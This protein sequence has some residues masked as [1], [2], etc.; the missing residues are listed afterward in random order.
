MKAQLKL[1]V[2]P[3]EEGLHKRL[4][5]P[6]YASEY[7]KT[8]LEDNEAPEVFLIAL[9]DVAEA[10]GMT[11][12]AQKVKV[13]RSALYKMLSDKGNPGFRNVMALVNRLGMKLTIQPKAEKNKKGRKAAKKT[14]RNAA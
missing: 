1:D 2:V 13:T 6:R 11:E 9:R 7:L 14:G 8:C 5:D 10:W 4:Q 12:L 3:Y